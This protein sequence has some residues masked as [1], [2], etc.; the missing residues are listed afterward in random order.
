MCVCFQTYTEPT[1]YL[2]SQQVYS[3]HQQGLVVQQGGTVTTI[4][5]SQP[6][7]QVSELQ[8]PGL[9]HIHSFDK[10]HFLSHLSVINPHFTYLEWKQKSTFYYWGGGEALWVSGLSSHF[11]NLGT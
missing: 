10:P 9:P 6:V 2:H 4:V 11:I 1:S 8:T 7:Q 5:T 3:A